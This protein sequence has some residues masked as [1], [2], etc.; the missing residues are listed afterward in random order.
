MLAPPFTLTPLIQTT[1]PL[2]WNPYREAKLI[3]PDL[4]QVRLIGKGHNW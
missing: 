2:S 1:H 3:H 4:R